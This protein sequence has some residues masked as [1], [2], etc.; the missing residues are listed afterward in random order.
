MD[1]ILSG[2][3]GFMKRIASLRLSLTFFISILGLASWVLAQGRPATA[4]PRQI[5]PPT[6]AA[7]L[8]SPAAV[9]A[10]A[11]QPTS[12]TLAPVGGDDRLTTRPVPRDIPNIKSL[13]ELMEQMDRAHKRSRDRNPALAMRSAKEVESLTLA[14]MHERLRVDDEKFVKYLLKLHAANRELQQALAAVPLDNQ[15]LARAFRDQG[16]T[17]TSCHRDYRVEDP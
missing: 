5:E 4:P 12:P 11:S 2:R 16:F 3:P 14:A 7:P 17:C 15:R 10:P 9:V 8:A 1:T 6:G 13:H